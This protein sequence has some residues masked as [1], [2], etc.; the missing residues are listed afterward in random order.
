MNDFPV[1]YFNSNNGSGRLAFGD[2]PMLKMTDDSPLEALQQFIDAHAGKH[3]LLN[4]SYELK[5]SIEKLES[6]NEN[7][8]NFPLGYAWVPKYMVEFDHENLVFVQGE[9]DSESLTFME[10]FMEEEIDQNFQAFPHRLQPRISKS[11]YLRHVTDIQE[12]IQQGEVYE[13]N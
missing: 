5:N 6:T 9:R 11:E 2:G 1:A 3:L 4:L 7:Y 13:V 12:L 8:S 10:N